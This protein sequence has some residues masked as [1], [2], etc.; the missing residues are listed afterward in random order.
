M[1]GLLAAGAAP[2]G[3]ATKICLACNSVDHFVSNLFGR[4]LLLVSKRKRGSSH[5]YSSKFTVSG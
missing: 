1:T 3:S 5:P 2:S 4:G